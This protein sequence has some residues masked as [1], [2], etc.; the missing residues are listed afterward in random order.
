MV[1]T[2]TGEL[3]DRAAINNRVSMSE[4]SRTYLAAGIAF[5]R[6]AAEHGLEPDR[7]LE[8]ATLAAIRETLPPDVGAPL[9]R[10][11]TNS[12]EVPLA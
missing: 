8:L 7:L 6:I 10:P 4:V 5:G 1:E 12:I 3:I 11:T 2:E 9:E